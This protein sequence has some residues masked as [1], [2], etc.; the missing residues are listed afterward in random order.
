MTSRTLHR[1][2]G[3]IL[4]LPMAGWALTGFIFFVKPGYGGAYEPLI[5][6]TY[7]L[8][9][10]PSITVEPEWLEY[11]VFR[12]IV[13]THLLVRTS[14]GWH[15]LNPGT[16]QPVAPP[17]EDDVRRLLTDAFTA[18]PPRYGSITRVQNGVISTD[19][20]VEV[21]LDWNRVSLQQKGRDT[22]RIDR[23][24]KVHYLQWTGVTAIDR[25]LGF[26]GLLLVLALT[27]LGVRLAL[28][29]KPT[30]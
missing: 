1:I 29:R 25:V 14:T 20:G 18:N 15:H 5:V 19:T 26:A 22:D 21:T 3:V 6:K 2:I 30:I 7:P 27:A 4:V 16:L 11:R 23:L 17:P 13:G 28:G 12:T 10:G 8:E 9:P 24:Y